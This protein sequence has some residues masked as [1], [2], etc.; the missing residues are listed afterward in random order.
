MPTKK[1]FALELGQGTSLRSGDYTRAAERAVKDAL[2]H[3]SLNMAQA[4]GAPKDA[5]IVDVE[6]AV[7]KPEAVDCDAVAKI[8][9]YGNITVS[10]RHGGLD[11]PK[12]DGS[13]STLV[14]HAAVIVSFMVEE[15][16][17]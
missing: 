6:I 10:A 9:P 11:I 14:A 17:A 13:G 2:W 4:F 5:M 7:Q 16:S 15:V 3:N 8:F 1:R 12:P